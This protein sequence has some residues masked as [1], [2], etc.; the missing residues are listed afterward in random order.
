MPG[1][2][3]GDGRPNILFVM[4]D[5]QRYDTI[6][7]NGNPLVSTPRLDRLATEGM[8]FGQAY[9]CL[10]ICAPARGSIMTGTYPH[11]HG[12]LSN[13]TFNRATPVYRLRDDETTFPA[14]LSQCGYQLGYAGK[15]H[16]GDVLS[17][18]DYG[19]EGWSLPGY[20]DV[21]GCPAY[22]AYLE[23]LGLPDLE[24]VVEQSM[25]AETRFDSNQTSGYTP[26]PPEAHP[27]GFVAHTA[28]GLLRTFA[29]RQR[30]TGRPFYL[31]V[32][33]WEPH[34]PYVPSEP[35]ASA[36][37]PDRIPP[38]E[39]FHDDLAGKPECL[40]RYRDVVYANAARM[41]W[42]EWQKAIA[43]Y[44]GAV[45]QIDAEVGSILD[46]LEQE[47]LEANTVVIYTSDHGDTAGCHG[48][49]FDKGVTMFEELTHLPLIVRWP[50][51]IAPASACD[52]FVSNVDYMPTFLELAGT[53]TPAAL[54]GR[55]LTPLLSGKAPDDWR[56][57]VVT[58][59][60]GL[61]FPEAKRVV[62]WKSFKYIMNFAS[63]EELYDLGTDP[64]ELRNLA[65]ERDYAEVVGQMRSRLLD[66]MR[67]T[68][69]QLGHVWPLM[70]Q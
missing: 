30:A 35:Y 21:R 8:R 26:G 1:K 6:G 16:V 66:H 48:G 14:L 37:D 42:P 32:H 3:A 45:S 49:C 7:A 51:H 40:R 69:D 58:E 60:H 12:I 39:N 23:H 65:R 62:R 24:P 5:Q 15:W 56:D 44:W 22:R 11:R 59:F 50:G 19:F 63:I 29:E 17:A 13:F 34:A 41:T 53:A 46:L 4:T 33:F 54:D 38:W 68:D 9:T 2:P 43:R 70:L 31:G 27:I 25:I 64:G 10:P 55:S 47:G 28:R 36:I 57:S 20:G 67:A 61:R 18:S 52:A